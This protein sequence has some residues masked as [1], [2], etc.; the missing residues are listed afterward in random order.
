MCP[1]G[2]RVGGVRDR[3]W[4]LLRGGLN[5]EYRP[6]AVLLPAGLLLLLC[7]Y[8]FPLL[9]ALLF[10]VLAACAYKNSGGRWWRLA[11]CGHRGAG[12]R[13][14]PVQYRRLREPVV[15]WSPA[16]LFLLM[17]SYLGKQEPPARAVGRGT[18]ELKERLT[19]PNPAVPTPARRLS[20]RET[21]VITNRTFMSPRRRYPTHQPQYSMPGSLPTVYVDGY[22]RKTL[23]SPKHSQLRSPMTVKIAHPDLNIARS[24]VLNNLLSPSP[25][26]PCPPPDPCAKETVLNALRESRKRI[27][28]D[29]ECNASGGMENKRRRQVSSGSGG[30][31]SESP[32]INGSLSYVSR[33]DTL[34]R[35]LN[36]QLVD[37]MVNKRSRTSSNSSLNSGAINGSTMPSHNAIT[38]S[39]SSSRVL[40]PKRKRNYQSTSVISSPPSSRSQTPDLS[41][42]KSREELHEASQSTPVRSASGDQSGQLIETPSSKTC[43][44]NSS[45]NGS[46]GPRRK[47]VLLV[48]SGRGD[49]YP[50]PPPPVVGYNITSKDLDSEKKAFLQRLN[51]ALEETAEPIPASSA[52]STAAVTA[53]PLFSLS[54]TAPTLTTPALTLQ[55]STASSNPLLQSLA[56]MQNKEGSQEAA[57]AVA[58]TF[59][60]NK[61]PSLGLASNVDPGP[62]QKVSLQLP[63]QPVAAVPSNSTS[64]PD[65]AVQ[66]KPESKS[67]LLQL[68]TQPLGNDLQSSFKPLF[69]SNVSV[70]PPSV[71]S[72]AQS[73]PTVSSTNTFKPIFGEQSVQLSQPATTFKPIFGESTGQ[74]PAT[75]ASPFPFQM[76]SNPVSTAPPAYSGFG[77]TVTS[78]T[79][80]AEGTTK[81]TL[82]LPTSSNATTGFNSA[83]SGGLSSSSTATSAP[84]NTFLGSSTASDSQTKTTF[85]FGQA[86]TS[87]GTPGLNM[88]GNK[89]TA[90]TSQPQAS[91]FGSTASAFS[92]TLN[93][94]PPPYPANSG[95]AAFNSSS[96][97][98]GQAEKPAANPLASFATS[99]GQSAF[100]SGTQPTFGNGSQ[101]TFGATSQPA[102]GSNATFNFGSA[103]A[104]PNPTPFGTL[105]STQTN[106]TP[107]TNQFGAS[108]PFTFG[109]KANT[110]VSFGATASTVPAPALTFGNS[111]VAQNSTSLSFG[112]PGPTENKMSF[113]TPAAPFGQ[114]PAPAPVT[115]GTPTQTFASPNASF[116][117]PSGFSIG[118]TSK[119]SG[120]RQRLMARRQ[121]TRKK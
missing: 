42:K 69:P 109:E 36:T 53:S 27:N 46:G 60:N 103:S 48:C 31:S 105:N 102:F 57:P 81:Q 100:G 82:P 75:S 108:K 24:P 88:F 97:N 84:T 92:A 111:S 86:P 76:N 47:K 115:F 118:V 16:S 106:S 113:G 71:S 80:S 67:S 4:R 52:P 7:V 79:Q 35:A 65:G 114:N 63:S 22:P 49:Q 104:A 13:Q 101:T 64:Q 50:L 120:A 74:Q 34:K 10:C 119:A 2:G 107:T 18:R 51:K 59:T 87:Q 96:G 62:S 66:T 21:P 83:F 40:L 98:G 17:G 12:G 3:L 37:E 9:S 6:V 54:T 11:E 19:R 20:F 110:A 44:L 56:K 26:S 77:A 55:T 68:L 5:R 33:S 73:A 95:V 121:H 70:N 58:A 94:N 89:P 30:S 85:V 72:S 1:S 29:E 23:L 8:C 45:D 93:S 25:A 116:G 38:S 41:A 117:Q 28:K 90:P 15:T 78:T 32:L 99:G 91:V 14:R 43:N 39:F 112:T 61:V